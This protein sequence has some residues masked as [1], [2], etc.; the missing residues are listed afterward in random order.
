M[1]WAF[2]DEEAACLYQM[3]ITK[4]DGWNDFSTSGFV[5]SDGTSQVAARPIATRPNGDPDK[6]A[7]QAIL[8]R[9]HDLWL[10]QGVADPER[11]RSLA[12]DLRNA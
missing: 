9:R 11:L 3:R 1:H 10:K 7:I 2:F 8:A 12:D 5:V 6:V 4:T